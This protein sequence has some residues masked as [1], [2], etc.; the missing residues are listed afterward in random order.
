MW[1]VVRGWL[2]LGEASGEARGGMGVGGTFPACGVTGR[3]GRDSGPA[4][5]KA[6][7][8]LFHW[9]RGSGV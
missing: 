1:G 9:T 4:A 2:R 8:A 3:A 6:L 7:K 5:L